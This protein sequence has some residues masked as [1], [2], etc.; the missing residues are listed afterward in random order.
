MDNTYQIASFESGFGYAWLVNE[1]GNSNHFLNLFKQRTKD[2]S[3]QNWRRAITDSSK[4]THYKYFKSNLDVEKYL[5]VDFNF[6][7]R[8]TLVNFRWSSHSLLIEKR[9]GGAFT[10]ISREN[11]DFVRFVWEEMFIL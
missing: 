7:C 9:G 6:I 5:F 1:I 11:I 4:A 10:Y 8:K 3:I 2:I